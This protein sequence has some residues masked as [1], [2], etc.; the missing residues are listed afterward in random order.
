MLP[1]GTLSY[2]RQIFLYESNCRILG[3]RTGSI[4][5]SDRNYDVVLCGTCLCTK[6]CVYVINSRN[7]D[8]VRIHVSLKVVRYTYN[9]LG[10]INKYSEME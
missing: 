3:D 7:N 1:L 8:D 2:K 6:V 10:K 4:G 9:V 5:R